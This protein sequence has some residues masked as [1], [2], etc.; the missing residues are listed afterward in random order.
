VPHRKRNR[1]LAFARHTHTSNPTN[2][3]TS[4]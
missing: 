1:H 3:N 4:W 2:G